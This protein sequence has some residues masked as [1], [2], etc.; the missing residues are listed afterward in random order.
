[1]VYSVTSPEEATPKAMFSLGV[2]AGAV[3][4]LAGEVDGG[5]WGL[6]LILPV[7][8]TWASVSHL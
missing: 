2:A 4:S 5:G 1:M 3:M 6:A 7:S 8:V